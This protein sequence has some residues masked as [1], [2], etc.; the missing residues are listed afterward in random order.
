[1]EFLATCPSF[2]RERIPGELGVIGELVFSQGS[3][4]VVEECRRKSGFGGGYG[5][6]G[7]FF[8]DGRVNVLEVTAELQDRFIAHG[9][10]E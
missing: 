4:G 3:R 5:G 2:F 10:S 6:R 7:F 8:L 9:V 1:M